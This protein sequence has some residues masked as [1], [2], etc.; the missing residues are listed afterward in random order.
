MDLFNWLMIFKKLILIKI[1]LCADVMG[2]PALT[3]PTVK[4]R[5]LIFK[6]H[7]NKCYCRDMCKVLHE[8]PEKKERSS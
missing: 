3:D 4:K 6:G 5:G 7:Y 8:Q 2:V 1:H